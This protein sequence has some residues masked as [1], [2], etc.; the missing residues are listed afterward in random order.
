MNEIDQY[1]ASETKRKSKESL[2]A[3]KS[4]YESCNNEW[5]VI[6]ITRKIERFR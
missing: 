5:E 6:K 2:L 4:F 1:L 3:W